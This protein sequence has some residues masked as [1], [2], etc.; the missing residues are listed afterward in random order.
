MRAALD[1]VW[2]KLAPEAPDYVAL[3]RADGY[4]PGDLGRIAAGEL[5][6]GIVAFHAGKSRT[7]VLIHRD[8]RSTTQTGMALPDDLLDQVRRADGAE[9]PI[10]VRLGE[11]E[12]A[13]ADARVLVGMAVW[14]QAEDLSSDLDLLYVIP[15]GGLHHL[16]LHAL[17]AA[18]DGSPMADRVAVAYAPSASVLARLRDRLRPEA[19]RP[20]RVLAFAP[21]NPADARA[22][23]E[24]TAADAATSLGAGT[25]RRAEA[26]R[27]ALAGSWSVLHLSCHGVFDEHDPFGSGVVLA[28]GLLTGRDIMQMRIDAEL[29][30]L[31]ACRTGQAGAHGTIDMAGLGYAVLY[32]GARCA[33]LTLWPVEAEVTRD[34]LRPFYAGLARGDGAAAALRSAVSQL[35]E[36][37]E[38]D[39][40]AVWGAYVLMGDAGYS[41]IQ[42]FTS[43][44]SLR[45]ETAR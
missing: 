39:D 38:Y 28:D 24:G 3:R 21:T 2:D 40:P 35:R 5:R 29:V 36:R 4:S 10:Y 27:D 44:G 1:A 31:A 18:P 26:T 32:A 42:S 15:D 19:S 12:P 8:G 17:P 11:E 33:L 45:K 43:S 22:L 25:L 9:V 7:T 23:I 14:G 41:P 37:P 20:A 16:P 6:T 34:L 30:V 13:L